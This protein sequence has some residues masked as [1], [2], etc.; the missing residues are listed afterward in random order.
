MPHLVDELRSR[1]RLPSP[2][3]ARAVRV[4]AG[5]TQDDIAR[6]LT[7]HRVTVARWEAGARHPRG[8]KA[9]AYAEL[10]DELRE[11]SC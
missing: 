7:V 5:A 6:E 10:L 11:L 1:H 8:P 3:V 9:A 4:A 2:A